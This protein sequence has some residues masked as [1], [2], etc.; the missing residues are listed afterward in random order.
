MA[1]PAE[2]L[3][4]NLDRRHMIENPK[5]DVRN[6]RTKRKT[7][8]AVCGNIDLVQAAAPMARPSAT[9]SAEPGDLLC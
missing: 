3:A 4:I 1:L 7:V 2:Y 9:T 8:W 6:I 5:C